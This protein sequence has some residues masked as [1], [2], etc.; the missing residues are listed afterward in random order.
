[1]PALKR[2]NQ[3]VSTTKLVNKHAVCTEMCVHWHSSLSGEVTKCH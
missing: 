2:A 1:M 3:S